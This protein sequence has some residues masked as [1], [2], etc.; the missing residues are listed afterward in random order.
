MI[1]GLEFN[2]ELHR[3]V[4]EGIPVPSV[5]SVLR[6]MGLFP[7]RRFFKPADALRG[8]HVHSATEIMDTGELDWNDLDPI[9]KPYVDAYKAFQ[10]TEN[11]E[12]EMTETMVFN[13]MLWY[14]GRLDR[15]GLLNGNKIILDIKTGKGSLSTSMGIQMAGYDM[16][17][18]GK[19][20]ERWVLYLRPNGK[21]KLYQCEDPE[22]YEAF[23]HGAWLYNWSKKHKIDALEVV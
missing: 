12:W 18:D 14:A 15:T 10:E 19:P 8:T 13:E 9:L 22:D 23:R 7:N 21:Y 3:Y 17:L 2:D 6:F 20:R 1:G 5:S 16:C 11:Y 4:R